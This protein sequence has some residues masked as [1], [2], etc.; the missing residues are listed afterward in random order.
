MAKYV[1]ML[2]FVIYLFFP[3]SIAFCN[4]PMIPLWSIVARCCTTKAGTTV[5][6]ADSLPIG[7]R[8]PLLP[9]SEDGRFQEDTATA[10]AVELAL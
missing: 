2:C 9:R 4:S 10:T 1:V 3:G 6:L 8:C 5:T 7:T